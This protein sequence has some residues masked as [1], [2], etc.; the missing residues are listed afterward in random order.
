MN[1]YRYMHWVS[2]LELSCFKVQFLEVIRKFWNW[3][4]MMVAHCEWT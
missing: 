4:V 3:A 2:D 1:C